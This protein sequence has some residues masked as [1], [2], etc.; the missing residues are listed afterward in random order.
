MGVWRYQLLLDLDWGTLVVYSCAN[1]CA[2]AP[3]EGRAAGYAAG[4]PPLSMVTVLLRVRGVLC[5]LTSMVLG[6]PF[7]VPTPTFLTILAPLLS[8]K[9]RM[10]SCGIV[11]VLCHLWRKR[12]HSLCGR[13]LLF[14]AELHTFMAGSV[15]FMAGSVPFMVGSVPFM[16]AML[17]RTGAEFVYRQPGVDSHL[18]GECG[19]WGQTW[20]ETTEK[21]K[22]SVE[23]KRCCLFTCPFT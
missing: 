3:L 14:V 5:M 16:A 6:L 12:A 9:K 1:S 20:R 2:I 8:L 15:P 10:F 11:V 17:T 19:L 23:S 21:S 18:E 7:S 22:S 13:G 4:L